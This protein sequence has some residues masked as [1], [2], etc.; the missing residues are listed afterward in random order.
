M[1]EPTTRVCTCN[2]KICICW[3]RGLDLELVTLEDEFLRELTS[4]EW[5]KIQE[6]LANHC[7]VAT[8]QNARFGFGCAMV[9][10]EVIDPTYPGVPL[11]RKKVFYLRDDTIPGGGR[12][13]EGWAAFSPWLH[14]EWNVAETKRCGLPVPRNKS[15]YEY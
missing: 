1:P 15:Y 4:N 12:F 5:E 11:E 13:D 2:A 6:L 7:L 10:W 3:L 8:V 9:L 14:S